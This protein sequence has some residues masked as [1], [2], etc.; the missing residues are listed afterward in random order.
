[1]SHHQFKKFLRRVSSGFSIDKV[2]IT[3]VVAGSAVWV[4]AAY[5]DGSFPLTKQ[6]H[7]SECRSAV[8]SNSNHAHDHDHGTTTTTQNRLQLSPEECRQ[9]QRQGFLVIDDFLTPTE[10]RLAARC[11]QRIE[12]RRVDKEALE[13]TAARFVGIR[14]DSM[15]FMDADYVGATESVPSEAGD[16]CKEDHALHHV[17]NLLRSVADTI[18]TSDFEGFQ[19]GASTM[20]RLPVEPNGAD[21]TAST[22][23]VDHVNKG[24]ND[25]RT[26]SST[27]VDRYQSP[28]SWIGVPETIQLSSYH[29]LDRSDHHDDEHGNS[30]SKPKS[31]YNHAHRD[32]TTGDDW[33]NST[34]LIGYM[35]SLYLRKRYISCIVYINETDNYTD[36][37]K[38]G[39]DCNN[40]LETDGGYLR[41]YLGADMNDMTGDS[42]GLESNPGSRIVDVSPKGGRLVLFSSE[43]VLHA[44]M[45]SFRQRVAC[46]IWLTLNP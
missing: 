8:D 28:S 33:W 46:T 43:H 21:T 31:N 5:Q 38:Q 42:I 22:I 11:A 3:T 14:K 1:M 19:E 15:C 4:Y 29:A 39:D 7:S 20:F 27:L 13:E 30:L 37:G 24:K 16:H 17:R 18:A 9:F 36:N 26:T 40:W 23:I 45:P 41:L 35:R 10:V 44:V 2:A 25:A 12:A 34:G 6:C 32:G